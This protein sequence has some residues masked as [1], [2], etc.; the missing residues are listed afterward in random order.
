MDHLTDDQRRILLKN[1]NVIELTDKHIHF[2]PDFKIKVVSMYQDGI[3]PVSIFEAHGFDLSFFKERY[4]DYTVKRWRLK[5]L[6]FG[7]DSLRKSG[8][9]I[10][11]S[12][13]P[14]KENLEH[15]TREELLTILYLQAEM[16]DD[17]KKMKALAR[18]KKK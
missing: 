3:S 15:F 7:I 16:L 5:A 9:G 13:R 1:P 6:K 18:K 17:I 10:D 14:R 8:T 2:H 11:A 12:G 4:V